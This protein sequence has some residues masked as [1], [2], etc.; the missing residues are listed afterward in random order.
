[1]NARYIVSAIA[2]MEVAVD[3]SAREILGRG[4]KAP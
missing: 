4:L 2:A 1:M 3:H